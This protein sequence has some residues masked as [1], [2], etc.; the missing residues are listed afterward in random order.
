MT[1]PS[2]INGVGPTAAKERHCAC[3]KQPIDTGNVRH[4]TGYAIP[5]V[6]SQGWSTLV[7]RCHCEPGK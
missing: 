2:G 5:Y 3:A 6:A 4:T 7:A 1:L